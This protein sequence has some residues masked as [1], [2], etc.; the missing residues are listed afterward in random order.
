MLSLLAALCAASAHAQGGVWGTTGA[1]EQVLP[2]TTSG[3]PAPSLAYR[4]ATHTMGSVIVTRNDSDGNLGVAMF[5]VANNRCASGILNSGGSASS[6]DH[7]LP[8]AATPLPSL[9]RRGEL[10]LSLH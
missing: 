6:L 3:S 7:I 2:S 1:W 10:A 5:D 4:G 9:S 8:L